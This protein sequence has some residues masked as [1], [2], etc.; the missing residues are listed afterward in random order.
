MNLFLKRL[1]IYWLCFFVSY[2]PYRQAHAVIPALAGAVVLDI[3]AGAVID[4]V[5]GDVSVPAVCGKKPWAANDPVFL[6][7]ARSPKSTWLGKAKTSAKWSVLLLAAGY[8]VNLS[9]NSVSSYDQ[10]FKGQCYTYGRFIT[11]TFQEC[12]ELAE[13]FH[14]QSQIKI[15]RLEHKENNRIEFYGKYP[16]G[17]ETFLGYFEGLEQQPVNDD[18]FYNDFW[19][20]SPVVTPDTWLPEA[21]PAPQ[22]H[23]DP[24]WFPSSVPV[25]VP[26]TPSP[27]PE[28]DPTTYPKPLPST[29]PDSRPSTTPKPDYT[30]DYWPPGDPL[31]GSWPSGWPKPGEITS[32]GQFP[33]EWPLPGSTPLP[34]PGTNPNPDPDPNPNPNPD[35][36]PFPIPLPVIGPITREEFRTEQQNLWNE[37]G[38]ALPDG[39]SIFQAHE[40]AAKQ[41]M[42]TF[43]QDNLNPEIPEFQF[44]PFGYFSFGGGSCIG[45]TSNV[46]MGK[47]SGQIVFDKHCQPWETIFRPPLEWALYL[48][49]A[50]YI[51]ILFSRTV[52]SV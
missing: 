43:I 51:Y 13:Y 10:Y 2:M 27:K 45:F 30:P 18:Q 42:D 32:P 35:P 38:N 16:N 39:T 48:S 14:Q 52:R 3:V 47:I 5:T 9:T 11:K 23:P 20:T 17:D 33:Q 44:S 15:S 1:S 41:A 36:L 31:P 22:Y 7:D 12:L 29:H 46:S 6:C 37:A 28:N 40:Q 19:Q 4:K 26:M 25:S 49:T 21:A 50:L 34:K 8:L 24:G